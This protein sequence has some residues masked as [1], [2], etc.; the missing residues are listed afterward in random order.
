VRRSKAR[1]ICLELKETDREKDSRSRLR[2]RQHSHPVQERRSPGPPNSR[3]HLRETI[4]ERRIPVRRGKSAQKT[5]AHRFGNARPK[6][7]V[8]SGCLVGDSAQAAGFVNAESFVD[9]WDN[10]SILEDVRRGESD[11]L[12]HDVDYSTTEEGR[13]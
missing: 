1:N 13:V 12:R 11:F 4:E 5:P 6:I 10:S 9:S 8:Q 2:P 3:N 7:S